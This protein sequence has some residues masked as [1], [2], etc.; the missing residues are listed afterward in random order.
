ENLD[1][2]TGQLKKLYGNGY[3][4]V[5]S[6]D[7]S[8]S[9]SNAHKIDDEKPEYGQHNLTK[10][11]AATILLNS[12]GSDG[13]N[14]GTGIADIKL[15]VM[16]PE[17]FSHFSVNGTLDELEAKAYYLYYSSSGSVKRYWFHT[18]PNVNILVT[19]TK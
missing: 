12:F 13:P 14:K 9:S 4:A 2:L 3:D 16:R 19:K 5:I 6:A 7:V 15:C 18:K 10:G 17:S 11:I 8:G 1:A